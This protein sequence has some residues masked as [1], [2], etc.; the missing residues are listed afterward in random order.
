M[1]RRDG[2]RIRPHLSIGR[3]DYDGLFTIEKTENDGQWDGLHNVVDARDPT[4][5]APLFLRSSRSREDYVLHDGAIE[6]ER[7]LKDDTE[8]FKQFSDNE[9]FRKW[10]TDTVFT[11]TYA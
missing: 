1:A 4:R 6:Q 5:L 11:L 8:L 2:A 10:L 9:S 7:L 3:F